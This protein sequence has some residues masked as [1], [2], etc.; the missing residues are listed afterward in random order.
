MC[1]SVWMQ[2][3]G[4]DF[5]TILERFWYAGRQQPNLCVLSFGMSYVI[6]M[7]Y[8]RGMVRR[9]ASVSSVISRKSVDRCLSKWKNSKS[10]THFWGLI[11]TVVR[12][13][14]AFDGQSPQWIRTPSRRRRIKPS[15][16]SIS[17]DY[18]SWLVVDVNSFQRKR[19]GVT[20]PFYHIRSN[21][22]TVYNIQTHFSDISNAKN[23]RKLESLA[24]WPY[25]I[26]FLMACWWN[27]IS[28][29]C[30]STKFMC[31]QSQIFVIFARK[32]SQQQQ[33]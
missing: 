23:K 3:A 17:F 4:N 2:P 9:L 26:I 16:R 13:S 29:E 6:C 33:E 32:G 27:P 30:T 14:C 11:D 24:K 21:T 31:S 12:C 7:Y 25:R 1:A 19:D 22:R 15:R 5:G 10:D 20:H 8:M 28:A 18:R